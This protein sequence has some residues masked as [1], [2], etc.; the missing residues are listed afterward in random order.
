MLYLGLKD[1]KYPNG[2]EIINMEKNKIISS[3]MRHTVKILDKV[4]YSEAN[5]TSCMIAF[6]PKVPQGL[7]RYKKNDSNNIK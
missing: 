4:L 6:Q 7:D 2:E 1:D 5:A 3:I